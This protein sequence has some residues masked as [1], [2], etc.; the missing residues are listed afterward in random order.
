MQNSRQV[1]YGVRNTFK[2]CVFPFLFSS[3]TY[4]RCAVLKIF[5]ET[6]FKAN[7]RSTLCSLTSAGNKSKEK[8]LG[9]SRTI[10]KFTYLG[11]IVMVQLLC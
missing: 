6:D 3:A 10:I 2:F 7:T 4:P 9:I 5:S 11:C 8:I 1:I